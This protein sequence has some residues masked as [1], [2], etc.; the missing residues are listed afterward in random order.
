MMT[1]GRDTARKEKL[2]E[3]VEQLR[4]QTRHVLEDIDRLLDEHPV[5]ESDER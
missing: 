5:A 2:L 1:K 4:E 3:E